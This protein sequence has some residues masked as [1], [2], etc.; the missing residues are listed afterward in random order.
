VS[1][2]LGH[3]FESFV[4]EVIEKMKSHDSLDD[5]LIKRKGQEKIMQEQY[6]P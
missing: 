6:A 3:K 4:S 5:S 1:V 2:S